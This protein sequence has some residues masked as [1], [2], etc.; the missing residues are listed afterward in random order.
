[1]QSLNLY[2]GETFFKTGGE[3][4]TFFQ[5]KKK[6]KLE[7]LTASRPELHGI[8]KEALQTGV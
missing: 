8:L 5:K 1:M 2:S 6:K 4:K 3:M 7:K